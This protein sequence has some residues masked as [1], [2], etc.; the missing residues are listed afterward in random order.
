LT[1]PAPSAFLGNTSETLENRN[2][3]LEVLCP[4][5]ALETGIDLHRDCP[6]RLCCA[7]R[8]SQPLSALIPPVSVPALFHAGSTPGILPFR[9]FPSLKAVTPSDARSPHDVT[10]RVPSN[11]SQQAAFRLTSP[12]WPPPGFYSLSESVHT[13]PSVTSNTAADPLLDSS[14]SKGLPRCA[15]STP[16]RTLLSHALTP[17]R[18]T[19]K[20]GSPSPGTS[21]YYSTHRVACLRKDR[22]PSWGLFPFHSSHSFKVR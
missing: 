4:S 19:R 2:S 18:F 1:R 20:L 14:P 7:L 17:V 11:G 3:S 8:F 10:W 6:S 12:A 21:E 22:R 9:V 15:I 16:S 5:S 13:M